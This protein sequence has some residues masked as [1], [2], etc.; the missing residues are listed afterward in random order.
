MTRLTVRAPCPCQP[1]RRTKPP[2]RD[3]PAWYWSLPDSCSRSALRRHACAADRPAALGSTIPPSYPAAWSAGRAAPR[4]TFRGTDVVEILERVCNEVGFPAT[5]RVDQG[6]EF[7]SR[8]LDVWAYQRGD[9]VRAVK[10]P[11]RSC[12]PLRFSA[13]SRSS[14]C[15]GRIN[16]RSLLSSPLVV[17]GKGLE[18]TCNRLIGHALG[19]KEQSLSRL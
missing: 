1:Y 18:L 17:V 8:D 3:A 19:S 9:W 2:A 7:V 10:L 14:G 16:M 4:F 12:T 6:T 13:S 15:F 11:I 5:I